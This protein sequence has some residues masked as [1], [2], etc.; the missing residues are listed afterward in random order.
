MN[1]IDI[2]LREAR[3]KILTRK[4]FDSLAAKYKFNKDILRRVMLNK[5]YL[6]T[7]F[8]GVY[9]LK[10]YEE[11]KLNYLKYSPYELLALGLEKKKVRWY[12]G[13]NTALKLLGLTHEVFPVNVVINDNFNRT[14]PMKIAGSNFFFIKLKPA[15]FFN[16][17]KDKT[18]NGILLH[19]SNLE[20]TLL[21]MIYLKKEINLRE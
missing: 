18:K 13:L 2:I 16:I 15:L 20:K 3:G 9:Y 10:D 4:D 21:D 5:G 6:I 12:F 11:K 7:I 1:K 17:I 19:H 14:K 8:R